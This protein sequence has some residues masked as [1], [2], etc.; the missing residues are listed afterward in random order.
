MVTLIPV[1]WRARFLPSGDSQ[2]QIPRA[3]R[4]SVFAQG[5]FS[6]RDGTADSGSRESLKGECHHFVFPADFY[7]DAG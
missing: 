3:R 5:R 6:C 7:C 2:K 4:K 1:A